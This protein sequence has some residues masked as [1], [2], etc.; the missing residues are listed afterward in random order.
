MT[1]SPRT[2]GVLVASGLLALTAACSGG[3]ET[4]TKRAAAPVTPDLPSE[5]ASIGTITDPAMKPVWLVRSTGTDQA[6]TYEARSQGLFVD[7]DVTVYW[8]QDTVFGARTSDG[9]ELW[10]SPVDLQGKEIEAAAPY[11]TKDHEWTYFYDSNDISKGAQLVTVDTRTGTVKAERGV[12]D[13]NLYTRI[14]MSGDTPYFTTSEG[15]YRIVEGGEPTMVTPAAAVGSKR[16]RLDTLAPVEG[17]DVVVATL[18][19]GKYGDAKQVAGVQVPSGEVLWK[20]NVGDFHKPGRLST[21]A[22]SRFDGRWVVGR[23]YRPDPDGGTQEYERLSVL[24]PRTG[25]TQAQVVQQRIVQDAQERSH[26]LNLNENDTF[27]S[28]S[29]SSVLA[30]PGSTDV[31]FEDSDGISRLS[32][33]KG[34][35][36]WSSNTEDARLPTGQNPQWT[37]GRL[38]EDAKTVY[39]LVTSGVSGNVV[40]IDMSSGKLTGRWAL[41]GDYAAGLL[42][43]PLFSVEDDQL[44]LG[45]NQDRAGS[46]A[47]SEFDSQS[48]EFKDFEEKPEGAPNDVGW[49]SFPKR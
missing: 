48:E 27:G 13:A 18:N 38:S 15:V 49:F 1:T 3:E 5:V 12:E 33:E 45:R 40:S 25:R 47:E 43:K 32:P 44:V 10:R 41:P 35:L 17:S 19:G 6:S 28:G 37:L 26:V 22:P 30:V 11:A 31:L 36:S 29:L 2:L 46:L 34:G 39:A 21:A 16:L 20:R 42:Q 24:D 23:E 7:G 4:A 9:K 14:V 8:A